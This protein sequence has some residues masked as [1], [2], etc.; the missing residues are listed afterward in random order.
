MNKMI[1]FAISLL[2]FSTLSFAASIWDGTVDNSFA[3]G[4]GTKEDPYL[5]S[6]AS[7]LAFLQS[8]VVHGNKTNGMNFALTDD[9]VLNSDTLNYPFKWCPVGWAGKCVPEVDYHVPFKGILD[10]R[11]HAIIGLAVDSTISP[12]V[13]PGL[14]FELDTAIIRNISLLAI[15]LNGVKASAGFSYYSRHTK[16][17]NVV[18]QGKFMSECSPLSYFSYGDSV[19]NFQSH[20]I[21]H[22]GAGM[23]RIGNKAF[24]S[25]SC[26]TMNFKEKTSEIGGSVGFTA[27]N[28]ANLLN[29]YFIRLGSDSLQNVFGAADTIWNS[30]YANEAGE[31][32]TAI[33]FPTESASGKY[34]HLFYD[35]TKVRAKIRTA[36][37]RYLD[38]KS[39]AAVDSLNSELDSLAW[40]YDSC[41]INYGYPYLIHNPPYGKNTVCGSPSSSSAASGSSSSSAAE[42]SSSEPPTAVYAGG[43]P[44]YS[45]SVIGSVIRVDNVRDVNVRLF[46]PLGNLIARKAVY[47]TG[48]VYFTVGGAGMYLLRIG[49][50]TENVRVR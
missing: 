26:S 10:G 48:S 41:G 31:K 44:R 36:A 5:I 33:F 46:D 39:R 2:A 19:K 32:D 40:A 13:L 25:E 43:Q 49:G 18:I 7:Q 8:Y 29:C 35:E 28:D 21:C 27:A 42:S 34:K 24:I 12:D 11:G 45:V 50:R 47:G 37:A 9:I 16:Y 4:T 6:T 3:G 1:V 14:F 15:K 30:Y 20:G 22:S 38:L 17:E 23:M